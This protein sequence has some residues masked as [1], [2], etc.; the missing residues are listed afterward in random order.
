MSMPRP[1]ISAPVGF[2]LVLMITLLPT[3]GFPFWMVEYA[4]PD[5]MSEKWL[6]MVL[7]PIYSIISVYL[8]YISYAERK[9]LSWILVILVWLSF[10][11]ELILI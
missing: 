2:V 3:M 11:A 4:S 7:Y 6:L 1:K 10:A 8:A 5:M 9:G